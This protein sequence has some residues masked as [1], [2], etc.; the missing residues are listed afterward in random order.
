MQGCIAPS[1]IP[2]ISSSEASVFGG[3][4]E[5]IIWADFVASYPIGGMEVFRDDHNPASYLLFLVANNR[6]FSKA[7]QTLFYQRLREEQLMRIPDFM[8]HKPTEKAFYEVKPD[9]T[10]GLA[11]GI[12]KVGFLQ[13]TYTFFRLP[14]VSGRLF[15][16]KDH[17]VALMGS[18]LKATLKVRRAAPGLLLYKLCLESNGAIELATLAV[19]LRYI[20]R[21]IN[22]QR[23]QGK[24]HP[25]DLA[26]AFRENQ[27]LGDLAKALGL[28]LATTA[29]AGVAA[30]GWKF[31][32]KA[33]AKRF[34]VRGATA[35]VLAAADGPLPIGDL[36]AAGMAIW[37]VV[38]IIRLSDELWRDA[39]TI[40]QSGA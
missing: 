9:S 40:A 12:E 5:E 7:Q 38:D 13:A 33:V 26:P 1:E 14:Y 34:A 30:V 18:A 8:V 16:P 22:K 19:L 17:T 2:G 31:F 20:V 28:T 10:S 24:F 23:G 37:T 15:S 29:A 3:V 32:W 4:A 11:A 27:Q 25:V 39:G 36:V 35:A 21:E 6:Y